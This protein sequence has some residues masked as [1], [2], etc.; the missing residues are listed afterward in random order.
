MP[1]S[2]TRPDPE[3][4]SPPETTEESCGPPTDGELPLQPEP[5]DKRTVLTLSPEE[6]P[7]VS[8]TRG[9]RLVGRPLRSVPPPLRLQWA[10]PSLQVSPQSLGSLASPYMIITEALLHRLL[11]LPPLT[12]A[13]AVSSWLWVCTFRRIPSLPPGWRNRV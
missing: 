11:L 7:P 10:P 4:V 12:T 3:P 13:W 6:E 8:L 9:V 2:R 1:R 5:E